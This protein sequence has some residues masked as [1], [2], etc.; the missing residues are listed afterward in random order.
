MASARKDPSEYISDVNTATRKYL[1]D[2]K[3]ENEA[4]RQLIQLQQTE[5]ARFDTEMLRQQHAS[6]E[7]AR[8]LSGIEQQHRHLTDRYVQIERQTT[9]LSHLFVA[10]T[11]L[12][13][14]PERKSVITAIEEIICAMVGSE[15]FAV[16][17]LEGDHKSLKLI[18]SMGVDDLDLGGLRLGEGVI[19]QTIEGR[20]IYLARAAP[21]AS[22]Q[23][24][25]SACIPLLLGDAAV[26]AIVIFAL[27]PQ[28]GT[29]TGQDVPLF[30]LLARQAATALYVSRLYE[31][32]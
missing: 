12:H 18:G 32:P 8:R 13:E 25:F 24:G 2:L 26:G 6:T 22:G 27:L 17:E 14:Q 7:L 20:E 10:S 23:P 21:P 29:L 19:G 9:Q 15:Q 28:K 5:K 4:L 1:D 3:V 31:G 30:E 11:R 16:F